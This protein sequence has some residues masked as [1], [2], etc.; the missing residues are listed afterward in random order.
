LGDSRDDEARR[1]RPAPDAGAKDKDDLFAT[2]GALGGGLFRQLAGELGTRPADLPTDPALDPLL[3]QVVGGYRVE[4]RLGIG[5][6]GVVYRAVDLQLSRQVALKFL[7][8]HMVDTP[9]ALER[10]EREARAVSALSHPNICVLHGVGE[11]QGRPYLVLELLEGHT[12]ATVLRQGPLEPGRALEIAA[13]VADGLEAAHEA[14]VL[15]R[16][17]KPANLFVTRRGHV[18]ILDFGIAKLLPHGERLEDASTRGDGG[19]GTLTQPGTTPGTYA[20]M[21]PEQLRGEELDERSDLF[22]LGV[23][24]YEMLA[25]GPPFEGTS[26]GALIEAILSRDPPPL[27]ELRPGLDPRVVELVDWILAKDRRRRIA[28]AAELQTAL[29]S[30]RWSLVSGSEAARLAVRNRRG[31]RAEWRELAIAAIGVLAVVAVFVLRGSRERAPAGEARGDARAIAV[32]PF[33]TLGDEPA[34]PLLAH[35]LPDELVGVLSRSRDLAVRPFSE[36]RRAAGAGGLREVAEQLGADLLLTGRITRQGDRLRVGLEAVDA[37]AQRVVWRDTLDLA[38]GDLLAQRLRLEESVRGGLLPALGLAAVPDGSRPESSEAYRLYLESRAALGDPAPNRAA[39]AQLERAV[40]LDPTFAPA[41]AQLGQL[42]HI[43]GYYW[44]A[45]RG[46]LGRARRAVEQALELDP[47]LI[48]ASATLV[49][50][51][52]ETGDLLGA[53]RAAGELLDRRP[54][55]SAARVLLGIT[56]RYGGL[57][58]QAVGECELARTLDPRDPSQRQCVLTYLWAG[59]DERALDAAGYATSLLWAN[60]ITARLALMRGR[61]EE[62]V[63]LWA[64]QASPEAGLLRRDHFAE[65]LGEQ[66]GADLER[67]LAEAHEQVRLVADP[68]WWFASAGL[69]A[70]CGKTDW[71][72]ALLQRAAGGGYCVDPSPRVDPLL[73]PLEGRLA[74]LRRAAAECRDAFAAQ[75]E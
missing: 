36:S 71:A 59:L 7:P 67:R 11:H 20:Y 6:M 24:L 51:R 43:D 8:S 60:D 4:E 28:G 9:R 2:G 19:A 21:S 61:R 42:L 70:T 41:W 29:E 63:R 30:L 5:G 53:Y 23:V 47:D 22:S 37:G 25:G 1:A 44:S 73:R 18:K 32:L 12:L 66:P 49:E 69:F 62:A 54:G 13:A 68:E 46:Q 33:E 50:L 75:I 52:L 38:S 3:G 74:D 27:R 64:R 17:V 15:H 40:E 55:S 14:G 45:D 34:D 26:P 31:W 56:L 57:L 72:L 65:C 48:E 58:E 10:F 39:I 16:D 35:S